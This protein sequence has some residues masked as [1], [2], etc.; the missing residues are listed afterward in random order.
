[1]EGEVFN[2]FIEQ[3]FEGLNTPAYDFWVLNITRG[4]DVNPLQIV[5][6][7]NGSVDLTRTDPKNLTEANTII[8]SGS[9][10]VTFWQTVNWLYVSLYWTTLIDFGQYSPY[11]VNGTTNIGFY[12][13][14]TNNLFLNSTL[15]QSYYSFYN[16]SLAPFL[17]GYAL[18]IPQYVPPKPVYF[19]TTF[20]QS[21]TCSKLAPRSPL[22]LFI[23][24]IVGCYTFIVGGYGFAKFVVAFFYKHRHKGQGTLP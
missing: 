17:D 24:V 14:A 16:T 11:L 15:L 12:P 7:A 5:F 13:P 18:S 2:S 19:P 21:Y 6:L 23:S 9:D 1:M 10:N 4:S 8:P 3:E 22:T 20:L